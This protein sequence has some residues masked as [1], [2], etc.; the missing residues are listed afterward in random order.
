VPPGLLP[1]FHQHAVVCRAADNTRYF[2]TVN[3]ALPGAPGLL[4]PSAP[5]RVLLL[6]VLEALHFL[7]YPFW[8]RFAKEP[9]L[10]FADGYQKPGTPLAGIVAPSTYRDRTSVTNR[11]NSLP[12]ANITLGP[13][14]PTETTNTEAAA[15]I[16]AP[17]APPLTPPARAPSPAPIAVPS[18]TFPVFPR[19]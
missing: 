4:L 15:P 18:P 11:V 6:V 7:H 13:F 10:E 16:P 5:A 1:S 14:T 17:I 19:L 9:A 3:Y 12:G 8:D 2:A